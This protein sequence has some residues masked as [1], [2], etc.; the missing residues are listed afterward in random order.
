MDSPPKWSIGSI[1]FWILLFLPA[2]TIGAA[3]LLAKNSYAVSSVILLAFFAWPVS[4]VY[5]GVWLGDRIGTE[6]L[7]KWLWSIGF[8]LGFAVLNLWVLVAGCSKL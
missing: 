8:T 4:S 2:A 6:G 7:A 5:C 1:S 3:A